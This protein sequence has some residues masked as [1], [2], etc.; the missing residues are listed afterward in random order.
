MNWKPVTKDA[1]VSSLGSYILV[2]RAD[3]K[4]YYGEVVDYDR[5]YV[6]LQNGKQKQIIAF[7]GPQL[8]YIVVIPPRRPIPQ[9]GESQLP[10]EK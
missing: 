2:V 7:H 6:E 3:G 1:M 8:S 9:L 5:D 4:G 10:L